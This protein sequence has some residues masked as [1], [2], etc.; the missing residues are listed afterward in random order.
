[1]A[2]KKYIYR[3]GKKFGPYYYE[4][5]RDK[6]GKV[7]KKYIGT[8]NPKD[9][10][11]VK[12]NVF[13]KKLIIFGILFIVLGFVAFSVW[14]R[15]SEKV[16]FSDEIS[17]EPIWNC[18]LCEKGI[19]VCHDESDYGYKSYSEKCGIAEKS[20]EERFILS[21]AE[22]DNLKDGCEV[23]LECE[24]WGECK[25]DYSL[26]NFIEEEIFLDGEQIRICVDK[27]NCFSKKV[28][29]KECKIVSLVVAEK[30]NV[31]CVKGVDCFSEELGG[32]LLSPEEFEKIEDGSIKYV[33]VKDSDGE[34]V[35]RLELI[36]E[37]VLNID[38]S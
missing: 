14:D 10:K 29:K 32:V 33:E 7:R 1:M 21:V 25:I 6:N 22:K 38:L 18:G 17:D 36:E 20:F 16:L 19:R 23:D 15:F 26:N 30:I 12:K 5:Y 8:E 34:V 28:E 24:G 35:S 11:I 3:D 27:N 13:D 2:Y 31:S 37:E 9:V 4:S